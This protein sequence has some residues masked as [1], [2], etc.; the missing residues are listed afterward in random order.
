MIQTWNDFLESVGGRQLYDELRS[1]SLFCPF[2]KK[3]K[4]DCVADNHGFPN[5][6]CMVCGA[7][8]PSA[9]SLDMKEAFTLWNT[10]I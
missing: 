8:G 5:V 10:R 2:C 7:Q 6:Y 4:L 3:K 1:S 9:N